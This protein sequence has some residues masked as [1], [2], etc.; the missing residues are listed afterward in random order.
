MSLRAP[1]PSEHTRQ[2]RRGAVMGLTVAEAFMLLAFVLLMLMMLW[3]Q[4]DRKTVEAA[5]EFA[6]LAPPE[7]QAVLDTLRRLDQAGLDPLDPAVKEKFDA[8]IELGGEVGPIVAAASEAERRKLEELIRGDAWRP[9]ADEVTRETVGERVAARLQAAAEARA[10]VTQTLRDELGPV[11]AENGGTIDAQGSLVFPET[12]LFQPGKAD[13]TPKLRAFLDKVC[14]PWFQSLERSGAAIADLRIEGH[15]SSEWEG[16]TP[17]QAYLANLTL[18]QAR[19][20]AVLSTCL[21]LV[22]GPEGAWARSVAT[23]VGYSSSHPVLSG[24]AE[25]KDKS[26]RV[27][28]RVDYSDAQ[29]L[30]DI[31]S[32]V[33]GASASGAAGGARADLSGPA[34]P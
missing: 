5:E 26:R 25:D 12:V 15:A 16:A 17:E 30:E 18:S 8:I 32:D 34:A 4:E 14:L 29:V 31:G 9:A 23:A 10:A 22:P 1:D 20:H 11:V 33:A 2:Y 6:A 21:E 28:F 24:G 19:A 7:R 3:R 13:I 27:V